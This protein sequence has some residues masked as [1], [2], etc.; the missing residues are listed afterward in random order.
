MQKGD[1]SVGAK[2]GTKGD[3]KVSEKDTAKAMRQGEQSL[4]VVHNPGMKQGRPEQPCLDRRG[5]GVP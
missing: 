4:R 2:V 5:G 1:A 3:E